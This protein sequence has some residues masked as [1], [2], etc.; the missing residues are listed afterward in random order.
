MGIPILYFRIPAADFTAC[1]AAR[2]VRNVVFVLGLA[3]GPERVSRRVQSGRP[4]PPSCV[5]STGE[6]SPLRYRERWPVSL[7]STLPLPPEAS[8]FV[9]PVERSSRAGLNLRSRSLPA[10]C[11]LEAAGDLPIALRASA[12]T[13]KAARSRDQSL[14]RTRGRTPKDV[15]ILGALPDAFA[16]PSVPQSLSCSRAAERVTGRGR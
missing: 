7:E 12:H 14:A 16:C 11:S 6:R 2:S 15:L 13:T 8:W 1:L 4:C 3:R 5:A 9:Q 10:P